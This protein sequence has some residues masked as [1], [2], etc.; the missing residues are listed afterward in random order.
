MK[1]FDTLDHKPKTSNSTL[2][3]EMIDIQKN[4]YVVPLL[5]SAIGDLRDKMTEFS[6]NS[7]KEAFNHKTIYPI[8][9]RIDAILKKRFGFTTRHVS[10]DTSN[11]AIFPVP[12]KSFNVLNDNVEELY[13]NIS[14]HL[15]DTNVKTIEVKHDYQINNILS[16]WK[17]SID[18]LEKTMN[19]KGVYIDLHHATISGL[20]DDYV[21]YMFGDFNFLL[22]GINL[23]N[24]EVVAVM[25]HEIGHGFTHL[26]YSYRSVKNTG[27]L[28]DTMKDNLLNK[29]KSYRESL[30]L[31]YE[32]TFHEKLTET[33]KKNALSATIAVMNKY[34]A[35]STYMGDSIHAY[36]D[37]EQ[38][39]D[40]FSGRFGLGAELVSA[41]K[42]ITDKYGSFGFLAGQF[43]L[44]LVA[45]LTY[46][47]VL[48]L[49]TG[50]L[51]VLGNIAIVT[52]GVITLLN[53]I[54]AIF[55]KGGTTIPET[56]DENKRRAIRSRNELVRQLRLSQLN[57]TELTAMLGQIELT[58]KL[59]SKIPADKVGIFNRLV[60]A[61]SKD[62][63]LH[64]DSK[65]TEQLIEDLMENDLYVAAG[66]LKAL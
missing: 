31:A 65:Y 54:V 36:T 8:I 18:S 61:M 32:E 59:I 1:L 55:T 56:Y 12:P 21:L 5:E 11:Y 40:Q 48:V 19:T 10:T 63:K 64:R 26:E 45:I 3:T 15:E 51:A 23:S 20:P 50:G 9:Q 2:S 30:V 52:I 66:K 34:V 60:I 7:T 14:E 58:D 57:K 25:M 46:Y 22:N 6:I 33:E 42:A 24:R 28:V 37:S 41:L 17:Q 4:D 49:I 53:L 13:T 38:A 39:A 62:A 27:V 16:D 44:P 47:A 35:N 43:A 29:N